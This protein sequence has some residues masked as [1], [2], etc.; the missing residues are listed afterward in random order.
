M[1]S[2]VQALEVDYGATIPAPMLPSAPLSLAGGFL[3]PNIHALEI[4]LNRAWVLAKTL[5]NAL[6]SFASNKLSQLQNYF[7]EPSGV[8]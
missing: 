8:R 5:P 1:G 6:L 4:L 7:R 2:V 3:A